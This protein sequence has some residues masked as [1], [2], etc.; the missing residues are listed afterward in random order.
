MLSHLSS[1][2][3]APMEAPKRPNGL[4][5]I[6]IAALVGALIWIAI[7]ALFGSISW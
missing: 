4:V 6:L 3:F 1:D 5:A 2:W 7:F